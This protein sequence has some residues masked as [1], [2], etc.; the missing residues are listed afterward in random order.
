VNPGHAGV[1]Q[2]TVT[3]ANSCTASAATTV[4]V[5]PTPS[6]AASGSTVCT[7][8]TASLFASSV[9]N[10]T[11]Q[12]NGPLSYFSSSQ[13]PL[14]QNPVIAA[15]GNYTV[16]ATSALG[17]TN[18]AVAA[19]LV[20]SPPSLSAP[21]SNPSLCAQG[22]NGSPTTVT[23]N[24][25]GAF[26]YTLVADAALQNAGSAPMYVLN[27]MAPYPATLT[28]VTNT[29]Y[30]SNG[31]CT[32]TLAVPLVIVPNPTISLVH[33][34]PV[35]CPTQSFTFNANGANDYYWSGAVKQFSVYNKG[36]LMVVRPDSSTTY[37]VYGGTAGCFSQSQAVTL[38]VNPTPILSVFPTQQTICIGKS[39]TLTT[40]GNATSF[41]WS[42][43]LGLNSPTSAVVV[44][45]PVSDQTY[46]VTG[47]AKNCTRT[48]QAH[49][50]VAALPIPTAVISSPTVC[51]NG[52][53]SL[54]G[55]GG[56]TYYWKGP[57]EISYEG[58]PV[59][60]TGSTAH[61]GTYTLTVRDQNGC[62]NNTV[63]SLQ[64]IPL[65]QGS[66]MGRLDGCVPFC[67]QLKFVAQNAASVTSTWQFEKTALSGPD[68]RFCFSE[69][70]KHLVTGIIRDD[71]TQCVNSKTFVISAF[72]K[73]SADFNWS[74]QAPV[75]GMEDVLFIN[76]S[77]G[78][79]L[80][81]SWHF[82]A[83]GGYTAQAQNVSF[84][85]GQEG[86]FPVALIVENAAGCADTIVK[87]VE[88]APDFYFFI[89]NAFTVNGDGRND[90]FKPVMRGV[91]LYS[92]MI[93]NRWGEQVFFTKNPEQ[94]WDGSFHGASCKE[95]TY[96][97]KVS[98][99]TIHGKALEYNGNVTLLR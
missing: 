2:V 44:A 24:A 46:Y 62:M 89:P 67:T 37:N 76:Q 94:G 65:P 28:T 77:S 39:A 25:G 12:W 43:A 40:S 10:A 3:A 86:I 16:K 93:F 11:Y 33:P 53:V 82:I 18:N 56:T 4:V 23:L 13:N 70:G 36:A 5:N 90:E 48:V 85:F 47:S 14:I 50:T 88:V 74:P 87:S 1:Y 42:P 7:S 79:G 84:G 27:V 6:L 95:D 78:D 52:T 57:N 75:E 9:P 98:L 80:T 92:M 30:G 45:S 99:S 26:S 91:K 61:A 17:C 21:L 20:I 83:N 63:T 73:P 58:S 38:T 41:L 72:E 64:V 54:T 32:S 15:G 69:A 59:T 19:L 31:V 49:I 60:F 55:K 66:V 22:F 29:L 51:N 34:T 8:Q 96:I 68:F 97:W 71:Q 81:S 35:I